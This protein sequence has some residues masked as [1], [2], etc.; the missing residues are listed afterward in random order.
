M[1]ERLLVSLMVGF[2]VVTTASLSA[3]ANSAQVTI[4]FSLKKEIIW[5]MYLFVTMV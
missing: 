5:E 3:L 1:K 4:T 2:T